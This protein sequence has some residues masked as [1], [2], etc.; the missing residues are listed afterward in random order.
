[1]LGGLG[2]AL[3]DRRENPCH[4]IHGRPSRRPILTSSPGLD[5]G[6]TVLRAW[7]TR[8]QRNSGGQDMIG[9]VNL[10]R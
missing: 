6:Q 9:G 3:L 1:L 2:V 10:L 5:L 7:M 4:V 8:L